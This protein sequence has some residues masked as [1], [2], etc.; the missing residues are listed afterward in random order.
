MLPPL[1]ASVMDVTR[2]WFVA[3]RLLNKVDKVFMIIE[4]KGLIEIG[5]IV[6]RSE[7]LKD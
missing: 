6:L 5:F 2:A 1:I 7:R 4:L 3:S